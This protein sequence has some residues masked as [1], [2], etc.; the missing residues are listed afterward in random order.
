M[1]VTLAIGRST[2]LAPLSK[3]SCMHAAS[4][5]GILFDSNGFVER[6]LVPSIPWWTDDIY[7][8]VA[9]FYQAPGWLEI[10]QR[11][12]ASYG[13]DVAALRRE[14]AKT[15]RRHLRP[16]LVEAKRNTVFRAQKLAS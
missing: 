15:L 1:S 9:G 16:H 3:A 10:M 8:R 7:D 13:A 12:D 11:Y 4:L 5:D 2:G 6:R 14:A